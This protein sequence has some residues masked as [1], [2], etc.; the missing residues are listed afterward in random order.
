MNRGSCE[1]GDVHRVLDIVSD[2]NHK[3]QVMYDILTLTGCVLGV[4]PNGWRFT[5]ISTD[6]ES[7]L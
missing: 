4:S 6:H 1:I 7:Q 2:A 5:S 3:L